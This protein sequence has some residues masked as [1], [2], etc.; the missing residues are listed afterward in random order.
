M[1]GVDQQASPHV[2]KGVADV[3]LRGH[4]G[5]LRLEEGD[6]HQFAFHPSV[7]VDEVGVVVA[8]PEVEHFREVDDAE[9]VARL[10]KYLHH[11]RDNVFLTCNRQIQEKRGFPSCSVARSAAKGSRI[12]HQV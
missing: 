10:N 7:G 4:L 1:D 3:P 8:C 2:Y 6:V 5:D 11:K 12:A 9:F